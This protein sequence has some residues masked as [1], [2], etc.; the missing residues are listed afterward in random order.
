MSYTVTRFELS[1][2]GK[3]IPVAIHTVTDGAETSIIVSAE[4]HENFEIRRDANQQWTAA[5]DAGISPALLELIIARYET[6]L[7]G[8]GL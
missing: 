5:G 1:S 8:G 2:K 4:E 3:T 6:I 7:Q